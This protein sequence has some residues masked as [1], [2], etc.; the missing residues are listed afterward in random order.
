MAEAPHPTLGLL[1]SQTVYEPSN[2]GL[3]APVTTAD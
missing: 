3:S 2:E 1:L